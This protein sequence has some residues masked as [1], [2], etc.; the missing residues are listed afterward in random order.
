MKFFL[1]I[2]RGF[3]RMWMTEVPWG[4]FPCLKLGIFLLKSKFPGV[5]DTVR[6]GAVPRAAV[7]TW[8]FYSSR[9]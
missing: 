3:Y 9:D 1:T 4:R 5:P 6:P 2:K 7:N 8:D